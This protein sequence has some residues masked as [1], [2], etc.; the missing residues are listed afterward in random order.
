MSP[1]LYST[2]CL[3][4]IQMLSYLGKTLTRSYAILM[5]P[6]LTWLSG[7]TQ[8][9]LLLIFKKLNSLYSNLQ[10]VLK[11][12]LKRSLLMAKTL[13][14]WRALVSWVLCWTVALTLSLTSHTFA[15]RCL[16]VYIFL[17]EHEN[18]ST[19]PLL[20]TYITPLYIPIF[21]TVMRCGGIHAKH[22]MI[23]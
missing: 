13:T 10:N 18:S 14:G 2:S 20:K 3:P 8:T 7:S 11:Q 12:L 9:N 5:W 1:S 23:L 15:R 6:W 4:M 19:L 21:P 22:T 16:R 17:E